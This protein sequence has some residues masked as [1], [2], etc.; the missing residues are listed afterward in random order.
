PFAP[1]HI[2]QPQQRINGYFSSCFLFTYFHFAL[3]R[4][5]VCSLIPYSVITPGT[6][7]VQTKKRRKHR[8][9]KTTLLSGSCSDE[10]AANNNQQNNKSDLDD[11]D[12]LYEGFFSE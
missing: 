7:V 8:S 5:I 4:T 3:P 11:V 10:A 12:N 2:M 6:A 1:D 9:R